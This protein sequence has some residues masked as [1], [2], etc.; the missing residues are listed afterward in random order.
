M[1]LRR[2]AFS[3]KTVDTLRD[4]LEL[5]VREVERILHRGIS[6]GNGVDE[7]NMSG[8]WVTFTSSVSPGTET[9][10][11]HN[12][13]EVPVGYL[14]VR[15]DKAAHIYDGST[16]WTSSTIYLRSDVASVAATVFVF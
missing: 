8:D 7:D 3:G 15:R 14:V 10:I 16:T 1:Q 13:G 6:F 9:G 12:L 2:H 11:P 5:H 4:E